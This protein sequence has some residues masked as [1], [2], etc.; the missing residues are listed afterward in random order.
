MSQD[1]MDIFKGLKVLEL[2]S[3]LA[4][5]AVG[6]FFAE[7]GAEV[8]K[9][10]NPKVGGDVTRNWLSKG[11]QRK[12]YSAYFASVN[13][14]KK[15]VM[16]DYSNP[17]ELKKVMALVAD[18]DVII[19]N[20]KHGD[21]VKFGLDF[22]S[23]NAINSRL[24]YAQLHGFVSDP[25]RP[26]FD[27][28][29]Q[30]ETGFMSM[31][32]SAESGPIKMP[33]ALIDVLAAHQMKEAVLLALI[34]QSRNGKGAHIE[35]SL[36]QAALASL[37]NQATN[38]LMNKSVPQRLGSLHPNI[39]PYGD[40]FVCSDDREIVLA[41]G[42]DAQ[43]KLLCEV[44]GVLKE[45]MLFF[46]SN[47]ARVEHRSHLQEVLSE[48][49]AQ[50]MSSDL[51]SKLLSLKIPAGFIR[52]LDEVLELETAQAMILHEM[53]NDEETRRISGNAF[54]IRFNSESV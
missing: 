29:L 38:W 40:T 52:S 4:G 39:A 44:I 42:S 26:A 13:W 43:F 45:E 17:E 48:N 37:A 33:V 10:E 46:Q 14:G 41:V 18:S 30:A 34:N 7:L 3:V 15:H 47:K 53:V 24:I 20:F 8:T 12:G 11:E 2:A 16:L 51:M 54:T 1:Y 50:W 25:E 22:A 31:N 28:V 49:I 6:M 21:D 32:G 27:A 5:P 35:V 19:T 23:L 36:E 9:V